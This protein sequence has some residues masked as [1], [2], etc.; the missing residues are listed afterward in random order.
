[1]AWYC[2]THFGIVEII[3]PAS[4]SW[5][6]STTMIAATAWALSSSMRP[7]RQRPMD[8]AT[9]LQMELFAFRKGPGATAA[10]SDV[11]FDMTIAKD[12]AAE[13]GSIAGPSWSRFPHEQRNGPRL[14]SL[15]QGKPLPHSNAHASDDVHPTTFI[16]IA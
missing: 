16:V 1:M 13:E 2:R 11:T 9:A 12:N 7:P 6:I 10:S 14:F 3:I 8:R 5:A 4:G 15:Q